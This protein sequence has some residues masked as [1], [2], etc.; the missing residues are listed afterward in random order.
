MSN[1]VGIGKARNLVDSDG[2][3]VDDGDGY[4]KVKLAT[5]PSIDIGD[6]QLLAGASSGNHIIGTV[7]VSGGTTPATFDTVATSQVTLDDDTNWDTFNSVAAQEV[8]IT[9]PSGNVDTIEISSDGTESAGVELKPTDAL[10]LPI[11][12][13][14]LLEYRKKAH[15][16]T[17]QK[18]YIIALSNS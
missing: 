17:G 14:N 9:S 18:L 2:D 13:L 5:T 12:N 11:T 1:I 7:K 8:M 3:P 16:T 4:L 10:S 15:T 6:V